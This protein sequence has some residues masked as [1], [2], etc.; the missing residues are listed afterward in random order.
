M[1]LH[2]LF[3]ETVYQVKFELSL[4]HVCFFWARV[5]RVFIYGDPV[6]LTIISQRHT[7]RLGSFKLQLTLILQK[8]V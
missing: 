1:W 5:I 6:A 3:F 4:L 7:R 2:A 8:Y